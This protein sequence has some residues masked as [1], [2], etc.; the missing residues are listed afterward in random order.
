MSTEVKTFYQN[1][2][3]LVMEKV[4]PELLNGDVDENVI[5]AFRKVRKK[6]ELTE[7]IIIYLNFF[8]CCYKFFSFL[9]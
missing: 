3:N 6:K 2:V 1:I 9:L 4:K 5:N 7:N 8:F